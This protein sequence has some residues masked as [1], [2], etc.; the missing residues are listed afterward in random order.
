MT[1]DLFNDGLPGRSQNLHPSVHLITALW[2]PTVSTHARSNDY[3]KF[4]SQHKYLESRRWV[5][6]L[7]PPPS[8]HDRSEYPQTFQAR[9]LFLFPWLCG[10]STYPVCLRVICCYFKYMDLGSKG[11][12]FDSGQ[13][14]YKAYSNSCQN[15]FETTM[16]QNLV[17]KQNK[18]AS[19]PI[20]R[21]HKET[22]IIS[23]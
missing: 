17:R 6:R 1:S 13:G 18:R 3:E 12:E 20:Q 7:Y 22:V 2:Y 21:R 9:G 23:N 15:Y 4:E 5:H 8:I 10:V 14:E 16:L 11:F 19:V